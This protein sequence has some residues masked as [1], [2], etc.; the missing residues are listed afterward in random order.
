MSSAISH[1]T[2]VKNN[3]LKYKL[4]DKDYCL[5]MPGS[6]PKHFHLFIPF[7]CSTIKLIKK[8]NLTLMLLFL[9]LLL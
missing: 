9:F 4:I 6:R 1:K 8:E 2:F 5:F 3:I 7:I